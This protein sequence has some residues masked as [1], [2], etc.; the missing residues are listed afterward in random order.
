[1]RLPAAGAIGLAVLAAAGLARAAGEPGEPIALTWD[2]PPGCPREA[3][4][5]AEIE[6][7]LGGP[8]DPASRRYL[9]A[10]VRVSRGGDGFHV[11]LLTD[12]GG[13]IGERDFAGPTC[14]AVANAAALIVALT[15]DPQA[16]AR[17]TEAAAPPPPP[18]PPPSPPAPTSAAPLAPPPGVVP[19][20]SVRPAPPALPMEADRGPPPMAPPLPAALGAPPP[21]PVRPGFAVGLIAAASVGALPRVGGGIGGRVALLAGRF[22]AEVSALYWPPQTATLA[23][24]PTQ[25][26]D[27]RLITGDG[28]ACYA[29]LRAPVELSPCAGLEVGSMEATGFGARSNGSGSALWI[30]PRAGGA[31]GLPIGRHF[32]AR[33]D[34]AVIVPAERP[35][36]VLTSAGTVYTAGPVVGRATLGLEVRF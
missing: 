7:V 30:A 28:G 18:P 2:A 24:R 21:P 12:L 3:D 16:L 36:F 10:E 27:F 11:H 4:V 31:A 19:G 25:G 17:R 29:V 1:M 22:R 34:L 32:A 14:L 20:P 5:R 8:P 33:I 6:R 26:G 15:F 9:R 23:T 13:A 35:P